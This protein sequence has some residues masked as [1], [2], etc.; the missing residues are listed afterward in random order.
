MVLNKGFLGA[1]FPKSHEGSLVVVDLLQCGFLFV[2][3]ELKF[4]PALFQLGQLYFFF[5]LFFHQEMK[6]L[7]FFELFEEVFEFLILFIPLLLLDT[8]NL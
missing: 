7:G 4:F 2:F 6:G 8:H 5:V 3:V 1:G